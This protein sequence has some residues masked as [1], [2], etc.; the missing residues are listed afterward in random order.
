MEFYSL[1]FISFVVIWLLLYYAPLK[2]LK[3]RRWMILLGAS[4]FFYAVLEIRGLLYLLSTAASTWLSARKIEQLLRQQKEAVRGVTDRQQKADLKRRYAG[5]RRTFLWGCIV[6]NFG[7]LALLKYS[8]G[9]ERLRGGSGSMWKLLVVPIGISFYTFQ[10]IGYLADI[11]NAKYGSEQSFLKYLLFVSWFPQLM[12]GPINRY[13]RMSGSLYEDKRWDGRRAF[14]AL[15]LILF[16]LL[17][18]YA[19]AEQL[20]PLIS[21]IFD[22]QDLQVPGS[23]VVF[24][25]LLYSAQQYA[26]FSGGI[27]VVIGVSK[28]FG[29]SMAANFRQP[30]FAVTLGDFWRRWHISLGAW[31]RDYVF[32]PL[33]LLKC[34][35]RLSK[36]ITRRCSG[37]FGKHLG[38]TVPACIA[39]IVVFFIVGLW[40][41]AQEHYIA[42]GLYNGLVIAFSDLLK[43]VFA[44][45]GERLVGKMTL[46]QK[47]VFWRKSGLLREGESSRNASKKT[48]RVLRIL[49]TFLIVNIGWYFD[50]IEDAHYRSVCFHNT[51]FYFHIERLRQTLYSYDLDY[52]MKPVGIACIGVLIM[53]AVSILREKNV[54]V[55]GVFLRQHW[56]V[57]AGALS[58]VILLILFSFVFTAPSGGFLY[59]QF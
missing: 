46:L 6:L 3:G 21:R 36:W 37:T 4:I 43:P 12:Q 57:Q 58:A 48:G 18:K 24:G 31:M 14:E 22:Q 54:D 44:G 26:D 39:N 59:A 51:L 9:F 28:L 17:K 8:G 20:A 19:V 38:R 30:Y 29:V 16:G 47:A 45:I 40:H 25:I 11:Y 41:G 1:Q 5:K 27:D 53:L 34:M 52:V 2:A 7:I 23:V 49:R 10:S 42:W 56:M 33:A 32:Y 50:R 15:L 35:Q 13:D 55:K